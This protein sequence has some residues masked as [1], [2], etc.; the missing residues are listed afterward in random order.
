MQSLVAGGRPGGY[1]LA[2][3]ARGGGDRLREILER[4]GR[5]PGPQ[6]ERVLGQVVVTVRLAPVGREDH[7]GS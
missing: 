2:M 5:L 3:L 4:V 1:A 6:G 7:D